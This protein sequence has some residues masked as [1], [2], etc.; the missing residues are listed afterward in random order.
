[1]KIFF[2]TVCV[3]V[4]IYANAQTQALQQ[5]QLNIE[6]LAQLKLMLNNMY[7]GYTMLQNG[8]NQIRNLS[9]ENFSLHKGFIDGLSAISPAVKNAGAI[10]AILNTQS[11]IASEYK[12]VYT[13]V[14]SSKLFTPSEIHTLETAYAHILSNTS[15]NLDGLTKVLTPSVWQMTEAERLE[16]LSSLATDMEKQLSQLRNF[17]VQARTLLNFRLRSKKDGEL[18]RNSFGIAK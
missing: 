17:T 4:A 9:A 14:A 3:F 8:Y 5:L 16:F 18:L 12:Q 13:Q 7:S 10:A 11:L 6:K 1:M 15:R 2:G